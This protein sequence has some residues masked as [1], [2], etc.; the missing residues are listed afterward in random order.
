MTKRF[1]FYSP[2]SLEHSTIDQ[3]S[4]LY[5]IGAIPDAFMPVDRL[6]Y[7]TSPVD[8]MYDEMPTGEIRR[9]TLEEACYDAA[10]QI[11]A[12]SDDVV[13]LWS[14]GID[15]TLAAVSLLK[16]R[17]PHCK[18]TFAFNQY[19]VEEYP[20]FANFIR[21]QC[22]YRFLESN[23]DYRFATYLQPH[24]YLTSG[25]C[26]DQLLGSRAFL[27]LG[28]DFNTPINNCYNHPLVV[29]TLP[30]VLLDRNL[31]E[32]TL[33]TIIQQAPITLSTVFD[34][35]WYLNFRFKWTHVRW[36]I[37]THFDATIFQPSLVKRYNPFY[38]TVSWQHWSIGNHYLKHEGTEESYKISFK[39]EILRAT[40]DS[41]YL[42]KRKESSFPRVKLSKRYKSI[43]RLYEDGSIDSYDETT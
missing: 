4:T 25:D 42:H 36:K 2:D 23:E 28:L 13:L 40:K 32:E 24:Q 11:Y 3:H 7:Y 26:G 9:V 12:R 21:T 38:N 19:S 35:F 20:A 29:G 43:Y 30:K 18:I 34:L 5:K 37:L 31:P 1:L 8:V 15:S 10:M 33:S 6:G 17:P 14:G 39:Q 41:S 27:Q 16:Y 22:D